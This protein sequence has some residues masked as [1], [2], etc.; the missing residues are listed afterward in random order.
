MNDLQLCRCT[1]RFR[2]YP[3][4]RLACH[5]FLYDNGVGSTADRF[6]I[7]LHIEDGEDACGTKVESLCDEPE[8]GCKDSGETLSNVEGRM[9]SISVL[10]SARSERSLI[11]VLPET[12]PFLCRG[13]FHQR[14]T[15]T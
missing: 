2:L 11:F 5:Q 15:T 13:S 12:C 8:I 3:R 7:D 1:P 10:R 6:N 14:G 9:T 4:C